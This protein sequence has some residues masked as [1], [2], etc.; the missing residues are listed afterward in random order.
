[1]MF[2]FRVQFSDTALPF[3]RSCTCSEFSQPQNLQNQPKNCILQILRAKKI[4]V[5]R[6]NTIPERDGT[7]RHQRTPPDGRRC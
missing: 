7:V 3:L 4:T 2:V 1:M 6:S 5:R